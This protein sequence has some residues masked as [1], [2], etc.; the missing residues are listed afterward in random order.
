MHWTKSSWDEFKSPGPRTFYA[1]RDPNLTFGPW[2]SIHSGWADQILVKNVSGH[3]KVATFLSSSFGEIISQQFYKWISGSISLDSE[4]ILSAKNSRWAHRLI[5][6]TEHLILSWI[7]CQKSTFYVKIRL[8]GL[9][10]VV[11]DQTGLA[12][13]F[14]ETGWNSGTSSVRVTDWL[15]LS[16]RFL[17]VS[18]GRWQERSIH[19]GF[20]R[21]VLLHFSGRDWQNH[22]L[23]L[24]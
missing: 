8:V 23:W 16:H 1:C 19:F 15:V 4:F 7:H 11:K 6:K 3:R 20:S 17:L 22:G 5:V 12:V 21:S 10:M 24:A 2:S 13:T 18:S 14:P 9:T